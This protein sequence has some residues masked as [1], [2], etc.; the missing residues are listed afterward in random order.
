MEFVKV[1][2]REDRDVYIDG[3]LGGKTNT[4]LQ[5]DSGTHQFGLGPV[6][7][8]PESQM[9]MVNET[10]ELNPLPIIFT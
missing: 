3:E 2:F 10:S 4:V 5:V 7:Y 1:V 8:T 9:I 6:D